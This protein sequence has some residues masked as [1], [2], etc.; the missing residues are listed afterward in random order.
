[1]HIYTESEKQTRKVEEYEFKLGEGG[2]M[3]HL[4]AGGHIDFRCRES[5]EEFS[6]G[7]DL[8]FVD[9]LSDLADVIG[10]QVSSQVETQIEALNEQLTALGDRLRSS[11]S[12]H[13]QAAQRRVE[14][15]QRRLERKLRGRTGRVIV[16]SAFKPAEPVSA[17]ERALILQMVQEKKITVAE[18]EMLLNTL[19]GRK[20]APPETKASTEYTTESSDA[21][22]GEGNA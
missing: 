8:D 18:A 17:Q 21:K 14:H 15:A 12:R 6:F 20:P 3:V 1:M 19:E 16:N 5:S 4:S 13:A 10:E 11:G 7:T 9:D 22:E 2:A